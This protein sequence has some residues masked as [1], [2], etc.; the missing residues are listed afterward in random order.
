MDKEMNIF[1]EY[2]E[3]KAHSQFFDA[4]KNDFAIKGALMPDTHAGYSLPIGAAVATDNFILPSWI[5]FDIG[6]GMCALKLN[7][8]KD[9]VVENSQEIFDKIYK[10]VPVG[11][12]VNKNTSVYHNA[13]R[14]T[15]LT[16]DQLSKEGK[17]IAEKKNWTNAIGSLGGGN[18]F[19][20]VGHDENN[21]VWIVIH[22]GSRGVGH[23]IAHHYMSLASPNRKA[24][25]GHYG[26]RTDSLE[27]QDYINDMNWALQY[28]LDNRKEMMQRVMKAIGGHVKPNGD[29]INRNHNH[30]TER[31]GMWIHRK[32]A[33]HAEEGMDGVIPGNMRDGSFIVKGKGN[34]DS[35][36]S[37]SHGAGRVLGRKQAKESLNVDDF[38]STM[39][40][41]TAKVDFATLDESPFAYKDI[42]EVMEQQKDLVDVVAHIKP[43]INIKG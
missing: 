12:N 21:D 36:Y 32:G 39:H 3:G 11:F 37:S 18:H 4:M 28:A 1:A 35:L 17:E 20:E 33:T 42:F 25:E 40:G 31:D 34:P 6:C 7:V 22:S 14:A 41:I 30:A 27:G 9:E 10:M 16:L 8:S 43:L 29:L 19:I 15:K 2:V 24:S 5:G 26:F 23:G 13:D 38:I